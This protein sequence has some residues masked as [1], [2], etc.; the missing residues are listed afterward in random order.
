MPKMGGP[1]KV[2]ELTTSGTQVRDENEILLK[3]TWNGIYLRKYY[4]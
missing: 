2:M 4:K 3:H 1:Y